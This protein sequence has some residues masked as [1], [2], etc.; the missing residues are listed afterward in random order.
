[1]EMEQQ[2]GLH[3]LENQVGAEKGEDIIRKHQGDANMKL[4]DLYTREISE[5][6]PKRDPHLLIDNLDAWKIRDRTA[7]HHQRQ[8]SEV[9]NEASG[10]PLSGWVILGQTGT[11]F[12]G[13]INFNAFEGHRGALVSKGVKYMFENKI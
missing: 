3:Y 7:L 5:K 8:R 9:K 1:M 2:L 4:S 10:K 13:S 12:L 11:F 6:D